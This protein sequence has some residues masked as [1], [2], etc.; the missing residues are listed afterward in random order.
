MFLDKEPV[1]LHKSLSRLDKAQ[2]APYRF[3]Q[4]V[5]LND[6]MVE[7]LG[8][9]DY[10]QWVLEDTRRSG[11]DP[12]RYAMLFVTFYT[13]GRTQVPHTPERCFLGGGL[14][15]TGSWHMSFDGSG[16]RCAAGHQGCSGQGPDLQ[17]ES[18]AADVLYTFYANCEFACE[19]NYLRL[20]ADEAW[21][22][23]GVFQ[24]GGG[25]IWWRRHVRGRSAEGLCSRPGVDAGRAA[26]ADA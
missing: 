2:L 8:T 10:I 20:C 5:E 16:C 26:G 4:S 25:G 14:A 24:Q 1:P 21:C 9:R 15:Q 23:Q 12:L 22:A 6:E 18:A 7:A 13:G 17:Q 19:R 3:T 11:S